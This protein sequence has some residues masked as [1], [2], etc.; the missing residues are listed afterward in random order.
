M[1]GTSI[2]SDDSD[3]EEVV[4]TTSD[5]GKSLCY[6][7][8]LHENLS[9]GRIESINTRSLSVVNSDPNQQIVQLTNED[10]PK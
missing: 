1:I 10:Q 4:S 5:T 6:P 8:S 7:S 2:S 9:C 3:F